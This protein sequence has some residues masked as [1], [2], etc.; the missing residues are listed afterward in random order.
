M[1]TITTDTIPSHQAEKREALRRKA[2]LKA[3]QITGSLE[4]RV[5][6]IL[7]VLFG[8]WAVAIATFGYAALILPMLAFVPVMFVVLLLITIGK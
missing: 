6:S 7:A 2:A 8:L 1:T 5:L 3:K 4:F